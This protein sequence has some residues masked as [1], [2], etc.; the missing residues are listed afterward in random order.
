MTHTNHSPEFIAGQETATLGPPL[1]EELSV[2]NQVKALNA[3]LDGD[4]SGFAETL[5]TNSLRMASDDAPYSVKSVG[6][7]WLISNGLRAGRDQSANISEEAVNSLTQVKKL[8]D[9]KTTPQE[10]DV[11]WEKYFR[12]TYD[13]KAFNFLNTLEKESFHAVKDK[14]NGVLL[15]F[16]FQPFPILP[17]HFVVYPQTE[18]LLDTPLSEH[19][20]IQ[21]F[22]KSNLDYLDSFLNVA[23]FSSGVVG[24]NSAYAGAT[25]PSSMHGQLLMPDKDGKLGV[26]LPLLEI[27]DDKLAD[28]PTPV[29]KFE[30][31][32]ATELKEFVL[33]LQDR[34]IAFN[35]VFDGMNGRR[36]TLVLPANYNDPRD[37]TYEGY[38]GAAFMERM[39][40]LV[41]DDRE[42]YNNINDPGD[43]KR[44]LEYNS[45]PLG[46]LLFSKLPRNTQTANSG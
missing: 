2:K 42:L 11:I 9:P 27:S 24:Y 16:I 29:F 30:S 40:A 21:W 5:A 23:A 45:H 6:K 25:R 4:P 31:D 13:P 44:Y 26:E 12:P 18:K 37:T 1:G 19:K 36:R 46:E 33:F 17:N 8:W 15:H 20:N 32:D 39:G 3:I 14:T 43:I 34:G 35:I 10:Q 38:P 41:I 28:Y 22:E 7:Y